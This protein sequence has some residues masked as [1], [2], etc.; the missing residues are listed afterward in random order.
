M[1]DSDKLV[2][3]GSYQDFANL[4]IPEGG[5][6]APGQ[7]S[8]TQRFQNPWN[9]AAWNSIYPESPMYDQPALTGKHHEVLV[10]DPKVKENEQEAVL[11]GEP[12]SPWEK[13]Y[14]DNGIVD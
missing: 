2:P 12:A 10:T 13:W 5:S 8:A 9:P 4:C 11:M 6:F 3:R 1:T 14:L 7:Y